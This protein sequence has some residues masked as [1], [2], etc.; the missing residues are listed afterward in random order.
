MAAPKAV[1]AVP[2]AWPLSPGF[3]LGVMIYVERGLATIEETY[4]HIGDNSR[5]HAF[6]FASLCPG[7]GWLAPGRSRQCSSSPSGSDRSRI[8]SLA[9]GIVSGGHDEATVDN[10]TV[11][12]ATVDEATER[13]DA[14]VEV[15]LD[16]E[17]PQQEE[18][19]D[20]DAKVECD[21]TESEG[22]KGPAGRDALEQSVSSSAAGDAMFVDAGTMA[23]LLDN[24][25]ARQRRQVARESFAQS[26]L[27]IA[28]RAAS[29][30][31]DARF[32]EAA[33]LAPAPAMPTKLLPSAPV[34]AGA[35]PAVAMAPT[36][37]AVLEALRHAMNS[38]KYPAGRIV[39]G[40][41]RSRWVRECKLCEATPR[42]ERSRSRS[43]QGRDCGCSG[44]GR[45]CGDLRGCDRGGADRGGGVSPGARPRRRPMRQGI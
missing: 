39:R 31:R 15:V 1:A 16:D 41:H 42:Y 35:A 26:F 18:Q 21:E 30:A 24:E 11:D 10:A 9:G 28:A 17:V 8:S 25:I 19:E 27:S 2:P 6:E 45:R 32:A 34:L 13:T 12:E 33:E 14:V 40:G 3:D 23:E 22:L 20:A 7:G 37:M 36:A 4:F 43:D 5:F 44:D 38:G 29:R